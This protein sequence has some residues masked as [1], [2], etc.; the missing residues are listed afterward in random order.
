MFLPLDNLCAVY[1]KCGYID[2]VTE[3]AEE[4][5]QAAIQEVESLPHY[6]EK[7][8][9]I[10]LYVHAASFHVNTPF[11]INSGL[12]QMLGTILRPMPTT[13][14]CPASQEG[15]VQYSMILNIL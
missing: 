2:L 8:E 10:E 14:L 4:S 1:N 6:Q 12:S 15:D 11:I 3:A 5:M 7:G 13:Q 9:V